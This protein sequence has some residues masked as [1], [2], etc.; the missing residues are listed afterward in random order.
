[1]SG[2]RTLGFAVV[3]I[4]IVAIGL[5]SF[6][7][8]APP[9]GA[10]PATMP[11]RGGR[12]GGPRG[13]TQEQS[14]DWSETLPG[15]PVVMGAKLM[16]RA[17]G[18]SFTE[19]SCSDA[20]GNVFFIDQPNDRIMEWSRDHQL[21]TFLQSSCYSNGMCF[22]GQGNLIA[23]ADENDQLWSIDMHTKHHTILIKDYQGKLLNGPN[24]V[25]IRPDNG[26]MYITDPFY[27]RTWWPDPQR[28]MAQDVQAVYYLSPDR[29]TLTRVIDD[30]QQPNGIIGTPDS[31]TLYVSDIRGRHTY[32]YTIKADGSLTN[33]TL[34]NNI[35]SDGMTID[36]DGNIYTTG[37]PMQI[38]DKTG[39]LIETI[40][41][42]CNNCCFGGPDGHLLFI[43]ARTEIYELQM[44]TSRVG[45]Q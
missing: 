8:T 29:K 3:G 1:M 35:G 33:K 27:R 34:F 12:G 20:Y 11:A 24:D 44:K 18:F 21:S 30:M 22:D 19:G 17:D 4:S 36:S 42:M 39:K 6:G 38:S 31:K 15:S 37:G 16:K 5:V 26:G 28:A 14:W 23:C 10:T 9:G 7:Q 13:F 32:S 43:C 2:C 45:S 40:P 41:I 25:W